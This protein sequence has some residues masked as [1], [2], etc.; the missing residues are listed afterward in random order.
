MASLASCIIDLLACDLVA[1]PDSGVRT[2][3]DIGDGIQNV[4]PAG[5]VQ[6][7]GPIGGPVD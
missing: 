4:A 3:Q 5:L 6:Y 2:I 7:P 1:G